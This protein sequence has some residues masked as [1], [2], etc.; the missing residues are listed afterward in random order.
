MDEQSVET[1]LYSLHDRT[2]EPAQRRS[3]E[4]FLSL[5]RVGTLSVGDRRELCLIRN[6]S[7]GG[8]L[9]RA[10]SV[11]EQGT[12]V[13]IELKHGDPLNGT[14][15][16]TE[17]GCI[18]VS[19]DAPIDVVELIST[20]MG[21]PRPRMPR[22]ELDCVGWVREGATV[23][24]VQLINVS[25]GGL[26]VASPNELSLGANVMVTLT[27]LAPVAATVRWKNE[28]C[29]GIA[30]DRPL[31]LPMLVGWLQQQ[32]QRERTRAAG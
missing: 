26:K 17:D 8:M 10:F 25:Q 29:Y 31:G 9:I 30:F 19:F 15:R 28:D 4:R 1:T 21:G 11:V 2:P 27:G 24:R 23:H 6:L 18:G 3:E 14:V 22:I 20:S 5:L 7:G 32:Q 16:W 12:R 13:S